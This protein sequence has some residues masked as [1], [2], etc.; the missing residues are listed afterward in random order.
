MSES[1]LTF[2]NERKYSTLVLGVFVI[3]ALVIMVVDGL[4]WF[5]PRYEAGDTGHRL[6]TQLN[7]VTHGWLEVA[8]A[9]A[10]LCLF[11][12]LVLQAMLRV[13][14]AGPAL[15]LEPGG[16][17]VHPSFLR[18]DR[19]I[20]Y[21]AITDA[22]LTTDG[23]TTNREANQ[24]ARAIA[25]LGVGWIL[26]RAEKRPCL[27]IYYCNRKGHKREVKVLAPFARDGQLGLKNFHQ[28]LTLQLN[29][30][31]RQIGKP[32]TDPA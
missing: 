8:L 25:P 16:L 30:L 28:S 27:V 5:V 19:L 11:A 9:I 1:V 2:S 32:S 6:T 22:L 26:N 12:P 20:P 14:V 29:E 17:A 23:E 31:G 10:M 13:F 24:V 7:Y 4:Y 3:C 18:A 15:K 21:A